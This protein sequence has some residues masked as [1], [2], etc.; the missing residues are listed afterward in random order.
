VGG[1]RPRADWCT[2]LVPRELGPLELEGQ[3]HVDRR[4]VKARTR[5]NA[6]KVSREASRRYL[7]DGCRP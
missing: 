3:S 7:R 6:A 5:S 2:V 1:Q 4:N